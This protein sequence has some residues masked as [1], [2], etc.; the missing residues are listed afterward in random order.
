MQQQKQQQQREEL[1]DEPQLRSAEQ[2][3]AASSGGA[4]PETASQSSK[5]SMRTLS[6][7]CKRKDTA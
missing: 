4:E 2:P 3:L 7:T 6:V 5:V 1:A